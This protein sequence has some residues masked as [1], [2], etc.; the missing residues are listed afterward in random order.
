MPADGRAL[1]V[2]AFPLRIAPG[3]SPL[4]GT[5]RGDGRSVRMAPSRPRRTVA[6][7]SRQMAIS[8]MRLHGTWPT[9][10]DAAAVHHGPASRAAVAVSRSMAAP[11]GCGALLPPRTQTTCNGGETNDSSCC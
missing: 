11:W 6:D 10:I 9:L 7:V 1:L 4:R 8:R 5:P 2:Y 3:S